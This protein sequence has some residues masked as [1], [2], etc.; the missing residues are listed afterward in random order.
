MMTNSIS[1]QIQMKKDF[2]NE[3]A[4]PDTPEEICIL[5][6]NFLLY[7]VH[8]RFVLLQ[9]HEHRDYSQYDFSEIAKHFRTFSGNNVETS[10]LDTTLSVHF[11]HLNLIIGIFLYYVSCKE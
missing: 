6:Y 4:S 8:L 5:Y 9:L 10:I 7:L 3:N 2:L 11:D 1:D